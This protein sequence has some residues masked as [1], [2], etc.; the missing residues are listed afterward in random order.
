MG[1]NSDREPVDVVVF[2][3]HVEVDPALR[4]VTLEKVERV[5][6]FASDVRRVEVDYGIHQTRRAGDSARA[7]SSYTY[8][9]T[10]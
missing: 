10:S 1:T 5:A 8:P 2:G 4:A 9:T 6:K 7:R 3:K